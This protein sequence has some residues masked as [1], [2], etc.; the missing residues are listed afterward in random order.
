M[1]RHCY[2]W[3]SIREVIRANRDKRKL[4]GK[5]G[6]VSSFSWQ[7]SKSL[8]ALVWTSSVAFLLLLMDQF[9][10]VWSWLFPETKILCCFILGDILKHKKAKSAI[11]TLSVSITII[12]S[13]AHGRKNCQSEWQQK[14]WLIVK[15]F[16]KSNRC[17][18]KTSHFSD[19]SLH[20]HS[21][22]VRHGKEHLMS[23]SNTD[24]NIMWDTILAFALIH[25]TVGII[26][27]G[28]KKQ[29]I[30]MLE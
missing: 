7:G 16:E 1:S 15:D 18:N 28:T 24:F 21:V 29:K 25:L 23:R 11:N 22:Q 19:G 12:N 9:K 6:H 10:T 13:P 14:L 27:N 26:V 8:K 5:Q 3:M 20:E 30:K 4:H 2:S 17:S